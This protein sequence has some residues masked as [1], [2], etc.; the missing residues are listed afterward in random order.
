MVK[1]KG[2]VWCSGLVGVREQK[3]DIRSATI[4]TGGSY[5]YI[6][7]KSQMGSPIVNPNLYPEEDLLKIC[8]ENLIIEYH[9]G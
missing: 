6:T 5:V 2:K 7:N 8:L 4:L 9:Y 1:P 3:E